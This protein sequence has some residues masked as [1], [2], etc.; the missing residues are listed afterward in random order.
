M[1][2]KGKARDDLWD[3]SNLDPDKARIR[4]RRRLAK[5]KRKREQAANERMLDYAVRY[6]ASQLPATTLTAREARAKRSARAIR[7]MVRDA[8]I[9]ESIVTVQCEDYS[10]ALSAASWAG[11]RIVPVTSNTMLG[12]RET[13]GRDFESHAAADRANSLNANVNAEAE[14]I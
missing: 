9:P 2:V 12:Y 5:E 10:R 13:A 11:M 4:R 3:E 14:T 1:S 6:I 7:A 8:A